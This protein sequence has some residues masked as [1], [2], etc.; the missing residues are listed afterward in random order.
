MAAHSGFWRGAAP[1]L[2]L[3]VLAPMLAEVLPG[4][5]RLS[6]IFV[7]PVEMGV[8]GGGA[9]LIRAAVR[10]WRLGWRNMLLLA[11]ALVV[12]EEFV[13]QQTSL[14]P[15]A[16]QLAQ[17]APPYARAFGVNWIYLLWA[18][19]YETVFVVFLPVAL[20]E[21]IF[22]A[23]REA[24]W[25]NGAG[26]AAL[27]AC[28]AVASFLAWFSWTQ[29]ARPRDFHVPAYVPPMETIGIGLGLILLLIAA[30]IG[31]LRR[32]IARPSAAWAAPP[33]AVAGLVA[34][35]FTI[36]WYWLVLLAF[37][38]RPDFPVAVAGA[39]GIAIALFVLAAFPRWAA[40]PSW[41]DAHGYAATFGA[42]LGSMAVGFVGFI[43]AAPLDL[44][45]K[46]ILDALAV[47]LM[48][49]LGFKLRRPSVT[50]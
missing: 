19:G 14:A 25:V 40:H 4:A 5:T 50:A 8:W 16:I 3:V 47:A 38:I 7:F 36:A 11:L 46:A 29:I 41:R 42:M 27:A 2:T 22:P 31:P 1:A 30:A 17:G 6:S 20:A 10:H 44:Y 39:G 34:A 35:V 18:T 12:A 48:V 23:R 43:G 13:I 32:R 15:M 33:P 45:G 24:A 49:A 21:L 9:V 26:A 28:F 37:G